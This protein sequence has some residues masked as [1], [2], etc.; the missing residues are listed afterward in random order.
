MEFISGMQAVLILENESIKFTILIAKKEKPYNYFN[1]CRMLK[2]FALWSGTR[3]RFPLSP[4]VF[5]IVMEVLGSVVGEQRKVKCVQI[6]NEVKS[7]IHK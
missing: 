1:R 4:L 3:Q 7:S 2:T 5:Y 6:R